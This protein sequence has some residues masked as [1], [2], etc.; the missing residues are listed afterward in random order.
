MKQVSDGDESSSGP[1]G[2]RNTGGAC[3]GGCSSGDGQDARGEPG[4]GFL[5]QLGLLKPERTTSLNFS[6]SV[7]YL[8]QQVN[9]PL[10]RLVH[11][12]G[13]VYLNAKNTQVRSAYI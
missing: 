12:L 4:A 2:K 9:M 13:S 6:L 3:A 1:G 8:A 5:G 10:L 7:G 11:Q